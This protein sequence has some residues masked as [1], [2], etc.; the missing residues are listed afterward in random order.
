MKINSITFT[1]KTAGD[2]DT[3]LH[4]ANGY[5]KNKMSVKYFIFN[6]RLFFSNLNKNRGWGTPYRFQYMP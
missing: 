4:K 2:I 6:L 1:Y 3:F 5:I